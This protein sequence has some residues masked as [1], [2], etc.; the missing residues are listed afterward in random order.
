MG[1][2][3][4]LCLCKG[5]EIVQPFLGLLPELPFHHRAEQFG[6]ESFEPDLIGFGGN[7]GLPAKGVRR[8]GGS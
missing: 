1:G 8:I 7:F 4:M 2:C 6:D 3:A 5:F